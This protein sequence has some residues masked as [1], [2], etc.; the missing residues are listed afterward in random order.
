MDPRKLS[1][2]E[3]V[4]LCLDSKDEA[5]WTEFVR[6]YQPLI[7]GVVAKCLCFCAVNRQNHSVGSGTQRVAASIC[8][9]TFNGLR[10]PDF[11]DLKTPILTNLSPGQ[12]NYLKASRIDTQWIH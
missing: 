10:V 5:M 11:Y 1:A 4:E 6:R 8:S 2:Q 9:N 3:L 7:A 12:S